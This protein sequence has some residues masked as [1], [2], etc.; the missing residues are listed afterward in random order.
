MAFFNPPAESLLDVTL[1]RDG[2]TRRWII[3]SDPRERRWDCR[4]I[5]QNAVAVSAT[6][7]SEGLARAVHA[8]K[9]QIRS[10]KA[11]GWA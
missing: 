2:L 1:R 4:L 5:I 7:S 11:E 9:Q 10:A 8:W 6:F 3:S